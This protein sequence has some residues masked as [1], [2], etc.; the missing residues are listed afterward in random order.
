MTM[1]IVVGI[2]SGA[3]GRPVIRKDKP[4]T[5]SENPSEMKE[6]VYDREIVVTVSEFYFSPES[7][8]ISK[9]EKV[10]IWI[11]NDGSTAH[12][13]HLPDMNLDSGNVAPG[14]K[15]YVDFVSD[16]VGSYN[17]YCGVGG[18]KDLGMNGNIIVK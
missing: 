7:L 9:G 2:Y 15:G 14:N 1:V 12:N 6:F 13:L 17:F 18:H 4:S 3:K 8:N 5:V 11:V 10:R 16:R